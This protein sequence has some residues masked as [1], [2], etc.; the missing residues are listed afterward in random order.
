MWWLKLTMG[1]K[2][3][4]NPRVVIHSVEK[5]YCH[6]KEISLNPLFC[7][8]FGENVTFTKFM[9]KKCDSKCLL[10]ISILCYSVEFFFIFLSPRFCVKSILEKQKVLKILF[11]Q[12]LAYKK[13]KKSNFRA[14]KCVKFVDFSLL[15]SPILISRKIWV[16]EKLWFPHCVT[17]QDTYK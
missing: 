6:P 7:I 16:K 12:F 3:L 9:S 10:G 13:F 14:S 4:F 8:F 11:L 1:K 5:K 17:V 2:R 15:K